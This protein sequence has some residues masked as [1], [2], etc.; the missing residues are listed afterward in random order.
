MGSATL[1]GYW[2]GVFVAT[3]VLYVRVGFD[4]TDA[5][6]RQFLIP[7]LPWFGLRLLQII[8]WPFT[9][10][11]WAITGFPKSPWKAI[12]QDQQGRPVRRI[13]RVHGVSPILSSPVSAAPGAPVRSSNRDDD[14]DD[15]DVKGWSA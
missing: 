5:D 13:E 4:R 14:F 12:E 2:V 3:A 11:Y 10:A 6:W 15:D 1:I 7:N 9:L 8:G